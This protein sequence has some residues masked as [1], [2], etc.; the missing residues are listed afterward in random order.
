MLKILTTAPGVAQIIVLN[1]GFG[2]PVL[3]GI[4]LKYQPL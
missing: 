2:S 3:L 4:G 1:C